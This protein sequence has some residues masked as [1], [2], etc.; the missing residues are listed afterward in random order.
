ME[1]YQHRWLDI[2]YYHESPGR[3]ILLLTLPL[4]EK[5]RT[6]S[7]LHLSMSEHYSTPDGQMHF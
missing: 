1:G 3:W 5:I 2:R 6:E 4:V 7:S